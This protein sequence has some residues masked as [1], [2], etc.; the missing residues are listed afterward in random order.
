[1]RFERV[2]A[3]VLV[4][5]ILSALLAGCGGQKGEQASEPEV[6]LPTTSEAITGGVLAY[7]FVGEIFGTG[8]LVAIVADK[9]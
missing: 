5:G 4:G 8:E 7:E 3:L 2:P 1:M 6:R 9:T